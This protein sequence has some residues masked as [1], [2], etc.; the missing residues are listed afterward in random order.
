MSD[1]KIL[2]H[3]TAY[4]KKNYPSLT[5]EAIICFLVT[6]DLG[7]N[8]TVG[9][10]ARGVRMGEPQAYHHLSELTSGGGVGLIIFENLGDGRNYVHLTDIGTMAK[11]EVESAFTQ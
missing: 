3:A 8:P 7:R 1:Q 2:E 5:A 4:F 10:I 9:D 11:N 6:L